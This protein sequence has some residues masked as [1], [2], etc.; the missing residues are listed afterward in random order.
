VAVLAVGAGVLATWGAW[1]AWKTVSTDSELGILRLI[2]LVAQK[3]SLLS[4]V[5]TIELGLLVV[6]FGAR[7]K[8]GWRSH[9]QKIVIGLSTASIAQLATRGIWQLIAMHAAPQTQA[10]YERVM[11]IQEKLYNATSLTFVA[12]LVWWIACL[13]INE[14]GTEVATGTAN[15]APVLSE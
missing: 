7:F 3:T 9:T 4:D 5:I 15:S 10:E 12:V 14:P 6:L 2:Q 13:W 11:G 1:P 8:A